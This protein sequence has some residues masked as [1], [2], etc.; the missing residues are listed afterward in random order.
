MKSEG[1]RAKPKN[2]VR[3]NKRLLPNFLRIIRNPYWGLIALMAKFKKVEKIAKNPVDRFSAKRSRGRPPTINPSFVRSN[4][5]N[6]RILLE[7]H[8]NELGALLMAA[9][10]ELEV[11]NALQSCDL[12][13]EVSLRLA[14]VILKVLRGPNFPRRKKAQI[15]FLAD[16]I[17][18][19]EVVTPRRSRDICAEQRKADAQRHLILRYE[20]WIE[21]SCGYKGRSENHSCK[22][23]GAVLYVASSNS[24]LM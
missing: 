7:P 6:Y 10:T 3:K 20:Y 21:C 12:E 17:G 14:S 23:C 9:H 2:N 22:K 1:L 15:N 11:A 5:D 24:E 8:W 13:N 18:G 16:S 4:A 19:G